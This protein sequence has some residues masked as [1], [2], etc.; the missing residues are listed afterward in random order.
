MDIGETQVPEEEAHGEWIGLLRARGRGTEVLARCLDELIAEPGGEGLAMD[1]LL[2]R[3]LATREVE[4]RVLYIQ[5]DWADIDRMADVVQ[6]A[7]T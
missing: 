3:V 7:V 2:R 1:T 6:G 5:G 4:V